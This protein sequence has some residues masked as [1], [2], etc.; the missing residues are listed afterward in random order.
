MGEGGGERGGWTF[1][2]RKQKI[3]CGESFLLGGDPPPPPTPSSC[4][5]LARKSSCLH[6]RTSTHLKFIS[7][8]L[9]LRILNITSVHLVFIWNILNNASQ[10]WIIR[11]NSLLFHSLFSK[12]LSRCM[13]YFVLKL[14]T[15]YNQTVDPRSFWYK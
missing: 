2:R 3:W 10:L 15:G 13:D 6:T 8:V 1:G 5:G 14:V 11:H 7:V 4:S 12:T 9:L